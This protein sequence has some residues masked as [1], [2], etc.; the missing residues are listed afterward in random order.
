MKVSRPGKF[1]F[2][3][4]SVSLSLISA[5]AAQ[6]N[7]KKVAGPEGGDI[8]G[9]AASGDTVMAT[10]AQGDYYR[11]SDGGKSWSLLYR[12]VALDYGYFG[13]LRMEPLFLG[14]RILGTDGMGS[15]LLFQ[16]GRTDRIPLN[17][18][19]PFPIYRP[20]SF[21]QQGNGLFAL[22]GGISASADSGKTWTFRTDMLGDRGPV[23]DLAGDG[24]SLYAMNGTGD[25]FASQDQGQTWSS[26]RNDLGR[27]VSFGGLVGLPGGLMAWW[28]DGEIL[29]LRRQGDSL[30]ASSAKLPGRGPWR[31]RCIGSK[32]FASGSLGISQSSDGGLTWTLL[33][34]APPNSI[35]AL[36]E[37][38]GGHFLAGTRDGLYLWNRLTGQWSLSQSGLKAVEIQFLA[39]QENA[40]LALGH[41]TL[42]R[43]PDG[44]A[45]WHRIFAPGIAMFTKLVSLSPDFLVFDDS[46][47]IFP[48][49]P[50]DT[51]GKDIS[52]EFPAVR[53][54]DL[55]RSGRHWITMASNGVSHISHDNRK[56]WSAVDTLVTFR[57]LIRMAMQGSRIIM[58]GPKDSVRYS[59]DT[60]FTWKI[61][62][63]PARQN[64]QMTLS[65]KIWLA[66]GGGL[67]RSEDP[68]AG[69]ETVALG[70]AGA[71][72]QSLI[73]NGI[74]LF[75][76]TD[77]GLYASEDHGATWESVFT[78]MLR[79]EFETLKT[80]ATVLWAKT[81]T[82]AWWVAGLEET[83]PTSVRAQASPSGSDLPR[84]N[85]PP[86]RSKQAIQDLRRKPPAR[87]YVY[88][89][90]ANGRRI[91][92]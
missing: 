69:W 2:L 16:G 32:L 21:F 14:D 71:R 50:G 12:R 58:Q 41:H 43:S 37:I 92:Y 46:A 11:S 63:P 59:L 80:G 67:F 20:V 54:Q 33:T 15:L 89:V 75:A 29:R 18:P 70:Q 74:T 57:P 24:T 91:I 27:E 62:P 13:P 40:L 6:L 88:P 31:V 73:R 26:I 79:S 49:G 19:D 90:S 61:A 45:T 35:Q 68:T 60:G 39:K 5:R 48:V 82:G 84:L 56:A 23:S 64:L 3:F 25:L 55:G 8:Q 51:L 9:L 34:S 81:E 85:R 53:P 28:Q 10:T 47:R 86:G 30:L 42:H 7:W 38:P 83:S 76:T 22:S 4:L 87:Q 17:P 66:T 77:I 78:G 52:R 1:L 44:G 72:V 36:V 65:G